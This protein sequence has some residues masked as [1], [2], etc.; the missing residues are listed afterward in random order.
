[1]VCRHEG[2]VDVGLIQGMIFIFFIS[3]QMTKGD[4]HH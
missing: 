4:L 1:M 2:R 3:N